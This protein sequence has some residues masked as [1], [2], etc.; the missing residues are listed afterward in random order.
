MEKLISFTILF[1][2]TQI[3]FACCASEMITISPKGNEI[4]QNP[5][6]LI[7]FTENDYK[8]YEKLDEARFYLIDEKGYEINVEVLERNEGFY[9][10]AQVLLKPKKE[11]EVG[12]KVSLRIA[13]VRVQGEAQ[14]KFV[15]TIQSKRWEV[16]YEV[17]TTAPMF[18]DDMTIQYVNLFNSS[19]PG[20]GI[21]ITTKY[22]DNNE[23]K[24]EINK[25]IKRQI[26]IEVI[27]E[28]GKRYL[29]TTNGNQFGIFHGICGAVFELK[30]DT[31]CSFKMRLLDFSGNKSDESK[32]VKFKMG[33][34]KM[35]RKQVEELNE[36]LKKKN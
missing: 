14:K 11:L 22:W 17:D 31:S 32:E 36:G 7:D 4:P 21:N 3:V 10:W 13:D 15:Q 24:Y 18:T 8:I 9:I 29:L 12:R 33:N 25:R 16:K 19:A 2:S 1:L 23:Y 26:I 30:Q 28:E 35:N 6:I 27:N 5:I 20:H 34:S